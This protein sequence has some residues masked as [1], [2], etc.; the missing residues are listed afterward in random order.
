[1][2]GKILLVD[3]DQPFR[4]AVKEV[5]EIEGY[6]IIEAID[7]LDALEQARQQDVNLVVTDILMPKLEGIELSKR[8]KKHKPDLKIIGMTG[9]GQ[10]G[11]QVLM[12]ICM[13]DDNFQAVLSKPFL[14]EDLITEVDKHMESP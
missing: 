12:N 2:R 1:M 7:G 3:D 13:E 9:G 5:L 6:E 14:I 8:L 11:A 4:D 10:M